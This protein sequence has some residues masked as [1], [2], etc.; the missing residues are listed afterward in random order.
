MPM[1]RRKGGVPKVDAAKDAGGP[2]LS[3]AGASPGLAWLGAMHR[4]YWGAGRSHAPAFMGGRESR[5]L[6][7]E[8]LGILSMILMIWIS[9]GML[10]HQEYADAEQHA[11][12]ETANLALAF[13]ESVAQTVGAIDEMLLSVRA[14]R[15]FL[16]ERFDM[17]DW[18]RAQNQLGPL[19]AGVHLVDARGDLFASTRPLPP[20]PV[21]LADRE[22][23][24][25]QA[26]DRDDS[27]H[28]SRGVVLGRA[29]GRETIQLTRKLMGPDGAFAGIAV[30][31]LDSNELSRFFG[32]AQLGEGFVALANEDGTV[33]ARGP[34]VAG[35][36]GS[37]L[38]DQ[39]YFGEI[40]SRARG[41]VRIADPRGEQI[42]SFRKLDRY[43]LL[44]LVGADEALVF[45]NYWSVRRGA[46]MVGGVATLAVVLA[47]VFWIGLR[48]RSLA[49]KRALR[50]T[51][52]SISQGIVMVDNDGRIPVI[53]RRAVDLLR[54]PA[55]VTA[56]GHFGAS[57]PV[58]GLSQP[59]G[60]CFPFSGDDGIPAS[61]PSGLPV[62]F[63]ACMDDG[64]IVEVRTHRLPSG[65]MVQTYSDVTE[66]RLAGDRMRFMAH[67]DSLTGLPNRYL[68]KERLDQLIGHQSGGDRMMMAVIIIDLDGFK[69]VNDTMG[70]DAGDQ[71][72]RNVAAR[73]QG[74]LR[75]DDFVG[76]LGGDEFVILLTDL[77]QAHIADS[78]AQRC[79]VHLS[80]PTTVSGQQVRI[81]ASVGLSV[82]PLDGGDSETL[83]KHAD[84]ALYQAKAEGRGTY[85][86]FDPW[87][88]RSIRERRCMENDLRQAFEA[89]G[90]DLYFQPLFSSATLAVTG[91]E[92]LLRWNHPE[93]GFIPPA[94][95]VGIAEACGL[96][97]R[98]G[99]WALER[100][101]REAVGWD[102]PCPVAV[103]VSALQFMDVG[104]RQIVVDALVRTGLRPAMLEIELTES[105]LIGADER[106]LGIL[107]ELRSLGVQLVL[108]DF[109]TGYSSLSYLLRLPFDKIKIDK[110][111]VQSTEPG[112]K[113][114]LEAILVMSRRLG[115]D[116]VAE[117]VETEAQLAM[118]RR[119]H[120]TEVQGF[121]LARPM[122]AEDVS[123]FLRTY[124]VP[125]E[126][127]LAAPAWTGPRRANWSGAARLLAGG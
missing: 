35:A 76:R 84:V 6:L 5:S 19:T 92:A 111:F 98:I 85:R 115:L 106:V 20:V 122:P 112:A 116:V 54:L 37:S 63:D 13:D 70:H 114:I 34:V 24:K 74:L 25:A 123:E 56:K 36:V 126:L 4:I 39:P 97:G 101:C 49:S 40:R 66:Q 33:L 53:N 44:V 99:S 18:A 96:I 32:T 15:A 124:V 73:L 60:L 65:G 118:I 86:R 113:A 21:N 100:A 42:I 26:A 81:G 3:M 51:L 71:L 95:F 11:L 22:H 12:T 31:S 69:G 16:G 1:A 120:C 125:A 90:L 47:G 27:L 38:A 93:H 94:S 2:P 82:Y 61:G 80:E 88:T 41:V 29:T 8:L 127:D 83:L 102:T 107:R 43:P 55:G 91:F 121:L 30:L 46:F 105:V 50:V 9:A 78:L 67:H 23:F 28:I 117:G 72:L 110:S 59:G 103:N 119:Q 87:M 14:Y 62:S 58:P 7:P 75:R 104:F 17:A 10:M 77:P 89:G 68:L 109:G 45:A 57:M 52:E 108:D 48:R 64:S 79:C